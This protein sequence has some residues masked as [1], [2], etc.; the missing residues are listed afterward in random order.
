MKKILSTILLVLVILAGCTNPTTETPVDLTPP[1]IITVGASK[2][3]LQLPSETDVKLTV[4]A[5]SADGSSVKAVAW[6]V[7]DKPNG[8]NPTIVVNT[9]NSANV[10]GLNVAG[11]YKFQVEVTGSN[12]VKAVKEVTVTVKEVT[13]TVK[14]DA[15]AP[16][17][18]S[19]TAS[20][21]MLQLPSETTVT[22]NVN[23]TSADGSAV[24]SVAWTVT[25]KPNGVTPTITGTNPATVS[26]L[27]AAGEYKFQVEVTGNNGAT[28]VREVALTVKA[29]IRAP[30]INSATASKSTLQLPAETSVDLTVDAIS[31]DGSA[32]KVAWTALT[33]LPAGAN[34]ANADKATATVNGLNAAGTYK[35]K[36]EVTGHNGVKETK[37]VAVEVKAEPLNVTVEFVEMNVPPATAT[38]DFS[39]KNP[40]PI[41]I[42]Y[43]VTDNKG[44]P[45]RNSANGFNGVV[46]S[47][48]YAVD[49]NI[50]FTQTFYLNGIK[51]TGD[52][53]E[54]VVILNNDPLFNEFMTK[55]GD[56]GSV[57]LKE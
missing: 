51:I 16:I 24:K 26:G 45:V 34:I 37:E 47:S 27:T 6:T 52:N 21:S 50:T 40:L 31:A 38:V 43:T 57:T 2:S 30:I 35:F 1:T 54:R 22:L 19:A 7:V 53:S 8:A 33:E 28:E 5:T 12:D 42:T 23:A 4:S 13:V 46:K 55:N 36:V 3:E 14:A 9:D 44:G 48:D 10:T 17:I 18:N 56:T 41:G 29:D 25:G 15:S 32:V 49:G 39:P 11:I 20:K